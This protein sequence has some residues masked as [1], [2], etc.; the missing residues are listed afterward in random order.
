MEQAVEMGLPA[1]TDISRVRRTGT[2]TMDRRP[3]YMTTR[4]QA[5]GTWEGDPKTGLLT[6]GGLEPSGYKK[7]GGQQPAQ[8]QTTQ[9]PTTTWNPEFRTTGDLSNTPFGARVEKE[10]PSFVNRGAGAIIV[11]SAKRW[12]DRDV[13]R[14][15]YATY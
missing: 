10:F 11:N 14:F 12:F 1:Q 3:E 6:S 4:P 15:P 8:K 2:V 13:P 5:W 9:T 7:S